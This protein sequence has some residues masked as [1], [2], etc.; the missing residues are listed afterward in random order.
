MVQRGCL[1][2]YRGQA[3][4]AL[5]GT[6]VVVSDLTQ[7]VRYWK[8]LQPDDRRQEARKIRNPPTFGG[9]YQLDALPLSEDGVLACNRILAATGMARPDSVSFCPQLPHLTALSLIY[10]GERNSCHL[11]DGILPKP[12]DKTV[13]TGT[14]SDLTAF[15]IIPSQ[16]IL[17]VML[18]AFHLKLQRCCPKLTQKMQELEV[19][20]EPIAEAWMTSIFVGYAPLRLSVRA[21]D[22]LLCQGLKGLIQLCIGVFWFLQEHLVICLSGEGLRQVLARRLS[23]LSCAEDIVRAGIEAGAKGR[24]HVSA[25]NSS[26][27][28]LHLHDHEDA[29]LTNSQNLVYYLPLITPKSGILGEMDTELVWSWL[30]TRLRVR[31][32]HVVFTS[33]RDGYSLQQLYAITKQYFEEHNGK[34]TAQAECLLLIRAQGRIVGSFL[35]DYP[36]LGAGGNLGTGESFVFSIRPTERQYTWAPESKGVFMNCRPDSLSIGG[37]AISIDRCS[38]GP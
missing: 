22:V 21:L 3:W 23:E 8:D 9:P 30:P 26:I 37:S 24:V 4:R 36:R 33:A 19:S 20:P 35:S 38:S 34:T 17:E 25:V 27:G 15:Q 10:L 14:A 18:T 6:M 31:D 29:D 2:A 16:H 32:G 13:S 7:I 11:V 5:T 12:G 1:D 28:A